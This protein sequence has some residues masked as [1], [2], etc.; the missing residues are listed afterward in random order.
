MWVMQR[1]CAA[2]FVCRLNRTCNLWLWLM[3]LTANTSLSAGGV[4][5]CNHVKAIKAPGRSRWT[6]ILQI[7]TVFTTHSVSRGALWKHKLTAQLCSFKS[8]I[9]FYILSVFFSYFCEKLLHF[10]LKQTAHNTGQLIN[11]CNVKSIRTTCHFSLL[12]RRSAAGGG[13]VKKCWN[14]REFLSFTVSHCFSDLNS[15]QMLHI[16][17]IITM[18]LHISFQQWG[19]ACGSRS[20][21]RVFLY[22]RIWPL[23]LS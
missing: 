9:F 6:Y 14:V 11:E 21:S 20:W 13:S 17:D 1:G 16:F 12:S 10:A 2:K 15:D 18:I 5:M 19:V 3:L 8:A 4:R 23:T 7:F 22:D